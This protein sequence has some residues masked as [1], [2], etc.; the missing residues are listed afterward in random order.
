MT[1]TRKKYWLALAGTIAGVAI[2]CVGLSLAALS[3]WTFAI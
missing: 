2:L 3:N 1:I